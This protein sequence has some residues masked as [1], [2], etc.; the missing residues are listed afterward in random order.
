RTVQLRPSVRGPGETTATERYGGHSEITPVFL[1]ENV[2]G[3]LGRAKKGMLR[4]IDAHRLSDARLIFVARLDLPAFLQFA[5]RQTIR[6]VAV[7]FV[8]R[9]KNKRRLG[10]KLSGGFQKIQRAVG[11][12][13]KIG[14]RIA[15]CPVVTV[16]TRYAQ[17]RRLSCG[18]A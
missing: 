15:S 2:A 18:A 12:D 10:R 4:V 17:S 11:V 6:R 5:Q 8:R 3:N 9:S 14:L 13:G 1:N 7:D 16:A